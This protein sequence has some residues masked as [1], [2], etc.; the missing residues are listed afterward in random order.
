MA[1]FAIRRVG[2]ALLV[3]FATSVLTFLI[4]QAIPSGDPALRLAGK[5]STPAQVEAI[6]K[7]W[8]FDKPIYVQYVK[9]MGKI[10]DGSVISY[11]QQL[12]VDKT[13]EHDLPA[14]LSVTIGGA[15]IWLLVSVLF[16]VLSAIR[17]G[18]YLDR[19]LTVL[20]FVGLSMPAFFLGDIAL[21]YL[22]YKAKIFPLGDYVPLTQNPGQ[23]FTHLLLPWMTLAVLYIGIYSRILRSS[24]LDTLGEDYVRTARAKGISERRVLIRHALRNSVIPLISLWGLDFASLLGGGTILVE[25][26]FNINGVGK[27]VGDSIGRLDVPPI[28]VITVF[29]AF[30]VV[31]LSAIVDILY[32]ALDPRIRLSS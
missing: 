13:V 10:F 5:Y 3:M 12:N 26:V 22:G 27:Y 28:L 19:V 16:G 6:R 1:R 17:A 14:T 7:E 31:A 23:W 9:T 20:A 29:A 4:F 2:S 18:R 32:A 30:A 21:Y 15:V 24:L 11:T 25:E 8:G